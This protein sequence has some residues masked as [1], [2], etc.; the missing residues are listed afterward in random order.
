MSARAEAAAFAALSAGARFRGRRRKGEGPAPAPAKASVKGGG[1]GEGG[2]LPELKG[3]R[4]EQDNALRNF[5]RVRVKGGRP[6]SPLRSFACLDG[7]LGCRRWISEAVVALGFP[8]PTPV[9]RQAIPSLLEGRDLLVGAPTGSGKTLAYVVPLLEHL[10]RSESPGKPRAVIIL[11]TTPLAA[12][13]HRELRRLAGRRRIRAV[14]L[15]SKAVEKGGGFERADVVIAAPLRLAHA[16]EAG[17]LDLSG[18]NR[19]VLDEA[20][21]VFEQGF[22]PQIDA[23]LRSLKHPQLVSALFSATLPERVEELARNFLKDPLRILVG[24]RDA[25]A[26]SVRQRLVYVGSEEGKLLGLRQELSGGGLRPPALVFVQSQDRAEQ[27]FQALRFDSPFGEGGLPT[28]VMHAGCSKAHRER[29]LEQFRLGRTG[30]LVATEVLARGMDFKGVNTVVNYDCPWSRSEYVH[31]VGRTGRGG[32]RGDAVTFYTDEDKPHLRM[33]ASVIAAS[34]SDVP[35]WM[36]RLPKKRKRDLRPLEREDIM[37]LRRGKKNTGKGPFVSGS[38]GKEP[39]RRK[40]QRGEAE[41]GAGGSR[42]RGENG[43]AP[44]A[45][46]DR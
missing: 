4:A 31:R 9:Q 39:P 5:L 16:V 2:G 25:A 43:S 7:V 3:P 28:D 38:R 23:V 35:G 8:E 37:E 19:L 15:T 1:A 20:D 11:P 41:G 36:L 21:K 45:A 26:R 34:G 6:A 46:G 13:V 12:Q 44:R 18:V 10:S 42:G 17:A 22:L 27:L 30:V 14:L 32:M 24:E 40:K 33:V 29:A